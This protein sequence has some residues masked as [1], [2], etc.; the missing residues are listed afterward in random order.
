MTKVEHWESVKEEFL[1]QIPKGYKVELTG[2]KSGHEFY[3]SKIILNDDM[4]LTT[5]FDINTSYGYGHGIKDKNFLQEI[6]I[7]DISLAFDAKFIEYIKSGR[8]TYEI[9]RKIEQ[10][11][12][13]LKFQVVSEK[14]YFRRKSVKTLTLKALELVQKVELA[15]RDI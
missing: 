2:M 6:S 10:Q 3:H 5:Q 7:N 11:A 14:K 8:E 1:A 12:S 13:D 9:L 4:Y 15:E